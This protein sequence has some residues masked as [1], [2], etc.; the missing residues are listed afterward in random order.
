V[1][2]DWAALVLAYRVKGAFM[3]R[4]LEDGIRHTQYV[5]YQRCRRDEALKLKRGK[6]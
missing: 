5:T 6:H 1:P 2:G 4:E 3:K